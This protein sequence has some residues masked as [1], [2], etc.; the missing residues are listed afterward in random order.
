MKQFLFSVFFFSLLSIE[1]D[2]QITKGN[3]LAGGSAC[4]SSQDQTL[5]SY[6]VKGIQIRV[7]PVAGHFFKDRI[8]GGLRLNG[9]YNSVR[10]NNTDPDRVT[11]IGIGPFLRYYFL[12]NYNRINILANASYL[13]ETRLDDGPGDETRSS[14]YTLSAGP[15]I[16]FNSSVGL[17]FTLNYDV[18]KSNA[19]TSLA[20]TLFFAIGFQVHLKK[21]DN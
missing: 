12:P 10:I 2:A 20:K 11:A 16:F 5:N 15:V 8:A 18:Y 1:T 9:W 7:S 13:N 17:E 19:N 14:S 6:E 21:E 3:W 4:F